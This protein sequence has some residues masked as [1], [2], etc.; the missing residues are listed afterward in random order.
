MNLNRRCI[1]L[2]VVLVFLS[3]CEGSYATPFD[4]ETMQAIVLAKFLAVVCYF[5]DHWIRA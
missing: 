2:L 3:I 1:G 4:F 5:I